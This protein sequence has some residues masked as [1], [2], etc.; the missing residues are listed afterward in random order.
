M[1]YIYLH[2]FASGTQSGKATFFRSKLAGEGIELHVPDLVQD[3]FENT[4]VSNQLRVIHREASDESAVLIGSSMGGYLAAL[5]AWLH[6]N[7]VSRLLLLAP[8]FWFAQRWPQKLGEEAV[9]EWERTGYREFFHYGLMRPM[10]VKWDLMADGLRHPGA[11]DFQQPALIFHG[12]ADDVVPAAFSEEFA[13]GRPNV[14]LRLLPS[15][16][17]LT[18]QVETIWSESRAFLL[19]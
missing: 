13:N 17:Q 7:N 3:G 11:P 1:K 9:A 2:G 6:Q 19:G 4:T 12:I 8:A 14:S 5:Y 16:H 15:D 18:D 10:N